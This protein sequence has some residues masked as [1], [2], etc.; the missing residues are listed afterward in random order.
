MTRADAVRRLA[1]PALW[2]GGLLPVLQIVRGIV[3][4]DLG[5]DP[6][7]TIEL[8]TGLGGLIMLLVSLAITPVRRATGLAELIRLRK[9]A[10]LFAFGLASLHFA[11]YLVFDH[12]LDPTRV[13]EDI[14]EHPWVLAGF[15]AWLVM[16]PLAA[17]SSASAIRRLG[18]R[19]WRVLHRGAYLAAIG[20]VLHFLW[21]VKKDVREPYVY[22][23]VL[24]LLLALR[25]PMPGRRTAAEP[26]V[27]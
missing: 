4:G 19:R 23:A 18:G 11:T 25:L 9:P 16:V 5:A 26:T 13:V 3:T 1:L 22:I 24:V 17:T 21:L 27:S 6:I 20:G 8:T 10:G 15:T 7:R 14:I 12:S 2:L